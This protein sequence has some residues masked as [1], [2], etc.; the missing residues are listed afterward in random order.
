M[1][2][3]L[4]MKT[5]HLSKFTLDIIRALTTQ[6]CIKIFSLKYL[7]QYK[8]HSVEIIILVIF[9]INFTNIITRCFCSVLLN[10]FFIQKSVPIVNDLNDVLDNEL[11]IAAKENTFGFLK[12]F[13]ILSEEQIIISKALR[14]QYQAN[15]NFKFDVPLAILDKSIFNDIVNGLAVILINGFEREV[16]EAQYISESNKFMVLD[17]KYLRKFAGHSIDKNNTH[18]DAIKFA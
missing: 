10:S 15:F 3:K 5:N 8:T 18:L 4:S 14:D 1:L 9:W 6:S 2:N 11:S 7:R 13:E 17:N 12:M 16:F